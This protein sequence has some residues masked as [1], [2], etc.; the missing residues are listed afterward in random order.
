VRGRGEMYRHPEKFLKEICSAPK[1][2]RS[3]TSA[4]LGFADILKK[5]RIRRDKRH[6]FA[7]ASKCRQIPRDKPRITNNE[8]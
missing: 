5:R 8:Q 1:G 4:W 2:S 6:F 3:E 7:K